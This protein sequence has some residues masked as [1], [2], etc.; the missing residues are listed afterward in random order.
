MVEVAQPAPQIKIIK[1]KI[2]TRAC[3]FALFGKSWA[4]TS[5]DAFFAKE[6]RA[7]SQAGTPGILAGRGAVAICYATESVSFSEQHDSV[8]NL[9]PASGVVSPPTFF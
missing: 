3:T 2:V 5:Y 6:N 1:P 9:R 8:T 7:C 4:I